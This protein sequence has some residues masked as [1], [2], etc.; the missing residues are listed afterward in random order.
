MFQNDL[1]KGRTP[2]V[3]QI[4]ADG[5]VH[6]NIEL[7][8]RIAVQ[9]NDIRSASDPRQDGDRSFNM[10]RIDDEKR[11]CFGVSCVERSQQIGLRGVRH[12][13]KLSV[14]IIPLS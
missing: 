7:H 4:R 14:Y 10:N 13:P 11:A 2:K 6:E 5:A 8:G 12:L 1:M 3:P 9:V